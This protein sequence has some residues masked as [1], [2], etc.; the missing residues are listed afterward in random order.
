VA[1]TDDEFAGILFHDV[2]NTRGTIA[3]AVLKAHLPRD[4]AVLDPQ[5][6]AE[7]RSEFGASRLKYQVAIQELVNQ[8]EKVSSEETLGRIRREIVE[9][10][11]ERIQETAITYKKGRI[12]L[13]SKSLAL[14]SSRE[15]GRHE[16]LRRMGRQTG[17]P[18]GLSSYFLTTE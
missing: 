15:I 10:A 18:M 14:L 4:F 6:L 17:K 16:E 11:K 2:R 8:F 12:E 3:T 13:A 7:F 5:R 9:V 1:T